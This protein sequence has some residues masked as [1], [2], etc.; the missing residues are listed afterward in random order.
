MDWAIIVPESLVQWSSALP[1]T[2]PPG[3]EHVPPEPAPPPVLVE[4]PLVEPPLVEPPLVEP[5]VLVDPPV[6]VPPS[7]LPL[8][9]G[10]SLEHPLTTATADTAVSAKIARAATALETEHR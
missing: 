7:G 8:L 9:D 4:P 3:M 6:L 2:A 10:L 5:P 1:E